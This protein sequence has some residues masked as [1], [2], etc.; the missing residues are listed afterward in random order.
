MSSDGSK[1]ITG[2][3]GGYLYT[4]TDWGVTWTPRFADAGRSWYSVAMSSDGSKLYAANNQGVY[5]STNGGVTWT[6]RKTASHLG[7]L[8]VSADGT[9]LVF[10][11]NLGDVWTSTDSGATWTDRLTISP[12]NQWQSVASS[13][14]GSKLVAVSNPGYLW[15]SSDSGV[16]W[17]QKLISPS[18]ANTA[19]ASVSMSSDGTR[20]AAAVSTLAGTYPGKVLISYDG[21]NSWTPTGIG[22][23]WSAIVVAGNGSRISAAMYDGVLNKLYSGPIS[24]TTIVDTITGIK[25]SAVELVYIGNNQFAM[26]SSNG[27]TI[28]PHTY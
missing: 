17:T 8:G 1:M 4:S 26:V 9:K 10:A 14:D 15:L 25:D 11:E 18:G 22:T 3:E 27:M 28:P 7:Y 23:S 16:T 19:W 21:G 2:V 20:I 5:S 24:T 13:A 6:Q 12:Y